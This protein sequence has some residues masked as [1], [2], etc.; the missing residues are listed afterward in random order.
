MKGK[1][2]NKGKSLDNKSMK[3]SGN[4]SS[5]K[6]STPNTLL[7]LGKYG[8]LTEE[9]YQWR[10]KDKLCMFCGQPSHMVKGFLMSI[11]KSTKTKARVAKV[12]TPATVESKK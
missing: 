9:E 5:F 3:S 6:P 11:L 10:M 1:S 12:E 2:K 8:K 4:T 7:H